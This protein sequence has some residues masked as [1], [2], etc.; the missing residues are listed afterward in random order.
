RTGPEEHPH[1][2]PPYSQI[3]KCAFSYRHTHTY[4]N[5]LSSLTGTCNP[6]LLRHTNTH[7]HTH[8]LLTHTLTSIPSG[9]SA[10]LRPH[11]GRESACGIPPRSCLS[12][13]HRRIQWL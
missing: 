12:A 3:Y 10:W 1:P 9:P 11:Q 2:H 4:T 7:T 5:A 13:A 6:P 8:T